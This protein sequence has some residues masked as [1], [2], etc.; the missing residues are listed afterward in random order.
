MSLLDDCHAYLADG[1]SQ[2]FHINCTDPETYLD[3]QINRMTRVEFL[4]MLD[5]ILEQHLDAREKVVLA[6]VTLKD[7][8]SG[9]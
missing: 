2:E 9:A 8:K 3:Q 5:A 4:H 6:A 7:L 1:M